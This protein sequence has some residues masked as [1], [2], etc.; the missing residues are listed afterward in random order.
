[1]QCVPWQF[2]LI[3][4]ID[5]RLYPILIDLII[6]QIFECFSCDPTPTSTVFHPYGFPSEVRVRTSVSLSVCTSTVS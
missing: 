5:L 3:R 2:R 1:M 6:S 4:L